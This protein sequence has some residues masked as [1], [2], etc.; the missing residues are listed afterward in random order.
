[1]FENTVEGMR[2]VGLCVGVVLLLCAVAPGLF[3]K[4]RKLTDAE[5][6][7]NRESISRMTAPSSRSMPTR[8]CMCL[9]RSLPAERAAHRERLNHPK[10]REA[11]K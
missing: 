8:S 6:T 2:W 5:H 4:E 7:H 10:H 1:M 11:V 3:I 9:N